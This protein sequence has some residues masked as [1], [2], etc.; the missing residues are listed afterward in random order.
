MTK[1]WTKK[2][3][4]EHYL[5]L[6]P[7]GPEAKLAHQLVNKLEA[8]LKNIRFFSP[9]SA[10]LNV[11]VT[12]KVWVKQQT[13]AGEMTLQ[14]EGLKAEFDNGMFETDN[15]D[16]IEFLTNI[17]DDKRYPVVRQ[18]ESTNSAGSR[19]PNQIATR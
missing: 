12:P 15:E 7:K 4:P 18:D 17:Y 10:G 1:E 2:V 16:I 8:P 5:K 3:S 6:W 19:V 14:S 11:V 13:P 9:R